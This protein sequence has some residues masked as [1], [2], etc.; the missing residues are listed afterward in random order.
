VRDEHDF[1][2]AA[3]AFLDHDEITQLA[4]ADFVG[5]I[6]D[7]GADEGAHFVFKAHR[8]ETFHQFANEF[9]HDGLSWNVIARSAVGDE[10]ISLMI[11]EIAA[12]R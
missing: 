8:P 11:S 4:H 1:L 3:A 5:Q 10:A 7:L 12:P 9:F 2:P 6:F